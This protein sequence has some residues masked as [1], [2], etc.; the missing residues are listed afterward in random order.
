[1]TLE[2]KSKIFTRQARKQSIGEQSKSAIADHALQN[3]YV[4]DWD[5][6]K[7]LQMDSSVRYIG[8]SI[9]HVWIRKRGTKVK[10]H[11]KGPNF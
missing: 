2:R 10:N 9:G 7:V 4:I 3:N 8:E 5:D 11:D 6:E 1:M